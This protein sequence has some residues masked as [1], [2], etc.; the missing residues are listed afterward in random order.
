MAKFGHVML[1]GCAW[2]LIFAAAGFFAGRVEG[3]VGA[4]LSY[5]GWLMAV[6]SALHLIRLVNYQA[7]GVRMVRERFLSD[8]GDE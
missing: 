2:V 8:E 3:I 5:A 7:K 6:L 1:S 4:I